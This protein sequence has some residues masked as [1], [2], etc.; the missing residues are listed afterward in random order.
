[1]TVNINPVNDLPVSLQGLPDLSVMEGDNVVVQL[2]VPLFGDFDN[3]P[4]S[5]TAMLA[6]GSPLPAWLTFDAVSSSFS[7][8]P[9]ESD[10]GTLDILVVATDG[11][12]ASSASTGFNL[13]VVEFNEAPAMKAREIT[14]K[15]VELI[16]SGKFKFGRLNLANG[17]MVGHTGDLQATIETIQVVDECVARIIKAVKEANGVLIYTGDHGNA[18]VMFT[19]KDG[20][21]TPKTSHTLN[22]VPFAIVDASYT[23]EYRLQPAKNAGLSNIAATALN[24][25]GY[26]APDDYEPSLIVFK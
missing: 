4:L 24:L 19:E 10:I 23:D 26:Q 25:M 22:K 9:L 7:G 1:V 3:D 5:V 2:P 18:D 20:I 17:D 6:D 16:K 15:T 11:Q 12:P 14:D 8:I 21:R 13:Q